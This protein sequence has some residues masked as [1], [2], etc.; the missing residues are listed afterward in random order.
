MIRHKKWGNKK[1]EYFIETKLKLR[2][3]QLDTWIVTLNINRLDFFR[4][5]QYESSNN[6][7]TEGIFKEM[8][9]ENIEKGILSKGK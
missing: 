1:C 9:F 6:F 5:W 2:R 3:T 4:E 7:C 8:K